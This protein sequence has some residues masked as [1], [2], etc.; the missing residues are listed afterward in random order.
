M[1]TSRLL[2]LAAGLLL[3]TAAELGAV[4]LGRLGRA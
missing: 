1:R 4:Q 3:L 2:V